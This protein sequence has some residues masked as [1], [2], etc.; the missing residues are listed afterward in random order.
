MTVDQLLSRVAIE[1][2]MWG[3]VTLV[4]VA[5]LDDTRRI[6]NKR[7]YYLPFSLFGVVLLVVSYHI[8][9]GG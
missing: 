7:W 1:A 3:I 8:G 4:V 5:F 9:S 6:S 2:L